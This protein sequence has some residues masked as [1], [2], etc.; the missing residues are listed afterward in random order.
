MNDTM[1]NLGKFKDFTELLYYAKSLLFK[2][3]ILATIPI[4]FKK[5][6][7]LTS[8][9][10]IL[11]SYFLPLG[12]LKPSSIRNDLIT[13]LRNLIK[14]ISYKDGETIL[15]LGESKIGKTL[16]IKTAFHHYA[17]VVNLIFS[18]NNKIKETVLTN[19]LGGLNNSFLTFFLKQSVSSIIFWH[20]I[21]LKRP[22]IVI[23]EVLNSKN[24]RVNYYSQVREVSCYL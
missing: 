12:K 23:L 7:I 20:K 13:D 10:I 8:F 18:D 3:A 17:G 4:T 9:R 5:I 19:L 14:N 24:N 16:A 21:I 15:V 6:G 22:P 1:E 2:G 11:K